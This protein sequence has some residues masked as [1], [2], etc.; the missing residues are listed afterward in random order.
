MKKGLFLSCVFALGIYTIHA[1]PVTP[2][3]AKQ[4][5]ENFY[6]QQTNAK[7]QAINLNLAFTEKAAS[8]SA[9]YYVFNVNSADGFVIVSG[10]DAAHPIIGYSTK[11]QFVLP[12]ALSP[13]YK[14]L[15][16]RKKEIDVIQSK[17]IS[18]EEVV[19]SEWAGIYVHATN[20]NQKGNSPAS[21]S[22][23]SVAP[24]CQTTWNQ[25]GGGSVPY[26]DS[27]PGNSVTGCVATA[28]AQIMK[29][30]NYPTHGTGSSSYCDCATDSFTNTYGTL[31]ANYGAS[32]YNWANMPLT[33][34]N[35]Y[36]AQL[37]YDCGV[38]VQMDYDP[39]GSGAW[40][41]TTD[42]SICAQTSYVKYFGY[43]P[44]TIQ[45]LVRSNYSDAVW[46]GLLQNELVNGRPVQYAGDDTADG[47]TWVL[48]GIDL[49]NNF[50]M[51]W[52]WGGSSDGFFSINNLA[53]PGF[54][55]SLYHEALIGI[56]PMPPHA[57]DAG[58][59]NIKA[60][61]TTLCNTTFSPSVTLQNFGTSTLSTC[62]LNYSIDGNTVQIQNWSGT[63]TSGQSALVSL[64]SLTVTAGTH[65][66]SCYTSNPNGVTDSNT[67]NDQSIR[68][69]TYGVTASFTTNQTTLCF[70]PA[71]VQFTN[72]TTNASDYVWYFGD[73]TIDIS[74]SPLHTYTTS[75]T[76][77]VKLYASNCGGAMADS[78]MV[79]ISINT[80]VIPTAFGGT[81]TCGSKLV[82][83]AN[84]TG[85]LV[86]QDALGNQLDT[87][88]TYTTPV[89]TASTTTF[90]V[91]STIPA[92]AINGGPAANT[93]LGAGAYLNAQHVLYFNANAACVLQSVDI[94]A[95]N[96]SA[97]PVI[98]LL[99]NTGA[100][101]QT[102][103]PIIS[104]AGKNTVI[105]NWK[106]NPGTGY[107]LGAS[108]NAINLYRNALNSGNVPYPI[109]IGS[110]VSITGDDADSAHYYWF[111]NWK[112]QP[113]PCSSSAVAVVAVAQNCTSAGIQSINKE[114][115]ELFP[116]PTGGNITIRST[117]S[118]GL[119][120][121]Y[122]A[123]GELVFQQK[124]SNTT[125]EIDL[126]SQAPG[127]YMVHVQNQFVR[128]IKQ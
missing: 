71:P 16:N 22:S 28:M 5:A 125:M 124:N 120:N 10:D 91:A 89:L 35:I 32:T 109:N 93:T 11:N 103:T 83:S 114:G 106:V 59:L 33:S 113:A 81:T 56:E 57:S 82:L 128:I 15:K 122:N 7:V 37:M 19:A 65:T 45:G 48:D 79:T 49:N 127:I 3:I 104:A 67:V 75:G 27:C 38:S 47:H 23:V 111:Y 76:Y 73:G 40:V 97:K 126:N 30:W 64:P 61:G 21:V 52:G 34:S 13:L 112:V 86:W 70:V 60:P 14:W 69:F 25:N 98:Q 26:N 50:H 85:T 116:N 101:L 39:Q 100:V 55:P 115:L 8:G 31:H 99:D 102:Q 20:S 42:D 121:V 1:K 80:P 41:I 46:I 17:N 72:N 90:Y 105:L 96:T 4:I 88:A 9:A 51:N 92:A 117:L 118:L 53:T 123:L 74:A 68:F 66:L 36:V 2:V 18:A 87:G 62:V 110:L 107:Q 95:Q 77:Q 84:G 6:K 54:N 63:L 12:N 119:V 43:D 24:L 29:Y 58:V 78:Q 44:Y 108:G 94:Y